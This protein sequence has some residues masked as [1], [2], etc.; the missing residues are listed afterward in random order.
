[1]EFIVLG[2]EIVKCLWC[3]LKDPPCSY[4]LLEILSFLETRMKT[5][6]AVYEDVMEKVELEEEH[7]RKR[8]HKVDD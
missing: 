6:M 1:M 3:C 8:I 4:E 2:W 7:K 5:L